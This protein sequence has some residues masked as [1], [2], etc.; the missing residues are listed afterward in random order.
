[1]TRTRIAFCEVVSDVTALA[2]TLSV[3]IGGIAFIGAQ[4][5]GIAPYI[6]ERSLTMV[7]A[8]A[9]V[10]AGV[11]RAVAAYSLRRERELYSPPIPGHSDP[12]PT[13]SQRSCPME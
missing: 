10:V 12:I 13:L 9:T 11:S 1:M 5:E 3:G 4:A 6:P 2:A 8:G 7:A